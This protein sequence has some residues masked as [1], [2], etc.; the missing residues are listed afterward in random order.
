MSMLEVINEIKK[1][2]E[3]MREAKAG[4][5]K[6]LEN[7]FGKDVGDDFTKYPKK[8]DEV[9]AT[10][11]KIKVQDAYRFFGNKET[12]R[13]IWDFSNCTNFN[14]MC[15]FTA[16]YP[17]ELEEKVQIN[18]RNANS[19]SNMFEDQNVDFSKFVQIVGIPK[20]ITKFSDYFNSFFGYYHNNPY[21]DNFFKFD[22]ELD[23]KGRIFEF[24]NTLE[25]DYIKS[26]KKFPNFLQQIWGYTTNFN[27]PS[28]YKEM[29][30]TEDLYLEYSKEQDLTSSSG[31][32]VFW[33]M[34][35]PN[36]HFY[37][38][39]DFN[40]NSTRGFFTYGACPG[41]IRINGPG[42]LRIK[43]RSVDDNHIN[44]IG[45]SNFTGNILE[46]KFKVDCNLNQDFS[47]FKKVVFLEG[48][49][50]YSVSNLP[51]QTQEEL[52]EFFNTLSDNSESTYEN[53]I[54]I[55][56]DYYNLLTEDDVLIATDKGYTIQSV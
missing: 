4:I 41:T 53:I 13:N 38:H 25:N 42:F 6:S 35:V 31:G 33:S 17:D 39:H 3:E 55:S 54:K 29:T 1:N 19:W 44:R 56:S 9:W 45:S 22:E 47:N 8:I 43:N 10:N 11:E 36:V 30:L 51:Y 32:S 23:L 21:I 5:K 49:E 7:K 52:V 18:V 2:L 20:K 26:T 48:T 37:F 24:G 34:T 28:Y 50:F 46:I 15:R 27:N 12:Y 16:T 40:F 14:N